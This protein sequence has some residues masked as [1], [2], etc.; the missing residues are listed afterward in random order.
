MKTYKPGDRVMTND[1][2]YGTIADTTP[3]VEANGDI[4]YDVIL[5]DGGRS[6]QDA[7]RLMPEA[8]AIRKW[9][10]R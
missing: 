7:W 8:D 6:T 1:M 2:K 5:D 3:S 4:W 10:K 9:G